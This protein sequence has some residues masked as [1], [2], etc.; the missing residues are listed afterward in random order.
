M[1]YANEAGNCQGNRIKIVHCFRDADA[2]GFIQA[3]GEVGG[4]ALV[5]GRFGTN[6]MTMLRTWGTTR[7][8][9]LCYVWETT[10]LASLSALTNCI[11]LS[12]WLFDGI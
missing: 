5:R 6:R 3:I 4:L 2:T 1:K 9:S 12:I 11:Y 7:L 8:A 10:R